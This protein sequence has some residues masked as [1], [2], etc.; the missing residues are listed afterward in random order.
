MIWISIFILIS[1]WILMFISLLIWMSRI[2]KRYH[3]VFIRYAL[4]GGAYIGGEY[5]YANCIV[6]HTYGTAY[7]PTARYSVETPAW[8]GWWPETSA[9]LAIYEAIG[10]NSQGNFEPPL[11]TP[12]R[13]NFDLCFFFIL[14]IQFTHRR[15]IRSGVDIQ[16]TCV[17]CRFHCFFLYI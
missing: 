12:F 8:P 7:A 1:I 15:W 9:W 10:R 13:A 4:L 17:K 5:L 14:F 6:V 2:I 16:N 3:L 11:V